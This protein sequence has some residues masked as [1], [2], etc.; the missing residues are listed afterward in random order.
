MNEK[1]LIIDDEPVLL[2]LLQRGLEL[3]GFRV[4]TAQSGEEGFQKACESH[5]DA[6]ILDIIMP[7]T[8]GWTTCQ[9]IRRISDSPII[10]LTAR[11]S[12]K[13]AAKGLS[14]GANDYLTKPCSFG[15]L[16]S[17]IHNALHQEETGPTDD[18]QWVSEDGTLQI[19]FRD[20]AVTR[21]GELIELTPTESRLLTYL[22]SR[23]GQVVSHAEL[24][25]SVWGLE[26]AEE[27]TYLSVYMRYLCQKLEDDP[28]RPRY[29]RAHKEAGYYFTAKRG[30]SNGS[31]Q[32]RSASRPVLSAQTA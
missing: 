18:W 11:A 7:G 25:T 24:L 22:A 32:D 21:R 31:G 20:G 30:P 2:T 13:D 1:I 15:K 4:I 9:E 3:E 14:M 27:L 28:D 5:P 19:D 6:I 16:R 8:D 10:M 23:R 29:I 12:A 17:R 26:F